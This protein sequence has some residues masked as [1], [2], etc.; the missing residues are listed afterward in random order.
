[1]ILIVAMG[2]G[3]VNFIMG[4]VMRDFILS[5]FIESP[6]MIFSILYVINMYFQSFGAVSIVKVNFSWFYVIECGIFFVIFGVIILFGIWLVF[7][8]GFFIVSKIIGIGEGGVDVTWWV[9]WILGAVLF[10]F[11]VVDVFLVWDYFSQAGYENFDMGAVIFSD[12]EFKF[13]LMLELLKKILINLIILM[14]V[15]I[16]FC[17]GVF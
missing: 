14:V 9:F 10:V 17:I 8:V 12:D 15:V 13:I 4:Y 6:M 3:I 11:F 1:M 5:G 2:V 16:E 7:S